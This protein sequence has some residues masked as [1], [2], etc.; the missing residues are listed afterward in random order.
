MMGKGEA[1]RRPGS[2]LVAVGLLVLTIGANVVGALSIMNARKSALEDAKTDLELDTLARSRALEA[3]LAACRAD[4]LFL[5]SSPHIAAFPQAREE[6]NPQKARWSRLDAQGS[7]LLFLQSRPEVYQ[8]EILGAGGEVILTG[9]RRSGAPVLLPPGGRDAEAMAQRPLIIGEWDLGRGS[10]RLRARVDAAVLLA[11]TLGGASPSGDF[12]ILDEQGR[13]LVGATPGG[14]GLLRV[15]AP[16][17]DN[18]WSPAVRWSLVRSADEGRLLSSVSRLA[19]RYRMNV[20]FNL[21]VMSLALVLGLFG[22]R[23]AR[24]TVRLEEQARQQAR[25]RDLER[26]LFHTERLSTVV[27][28]AAGMAHEINNPLEGMSNYLKLM[29]EDLESGRVEEARALLP[30][31]REGLMRAGGIARQVLQLSNPDSAPMERVDLT[32]VLRESVEFVRGSREFGSV[33]FVT[34]LPGDLPPVRGNRLLLGQLFLNLLLNACQV[35]PEGG[36]V[37]I[38]AR[39]EGEDRVMTRVADRGP[40]VPPEARAKVF[41]PFYSSRHST[42]LGLSVCRRIAR[43][44]DAELELHDRAG[45][46]AEFRIGLRRA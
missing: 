43:Q 37:E 20:V 11:S 15:D 17:S 28:L 6:R 2:L 10:G 7:L 40:G 39:P 24:R 12:A 21:A 33:Q 29:E 35:Q 36:T 9:G 13:S 46:G 25:V 30:S 38:G 23:Q 19:A 45:G 3:E 41:E 1:E 34:D 5:A 8:I 44:H 27:R 18:G 14:V 16:V 42:G 32:D 4:L 31:L 22:L 26:Q